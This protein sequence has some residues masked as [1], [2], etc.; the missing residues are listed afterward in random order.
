M[1]LRQERRPARPGVIDRASATDRAFL[2]MGDRRI[3]EQLGVALVL[4]PGDRPFD[5]ARAR[6]LVGDRSSAVPRLRQRLVAAPVGCGGPIWVDDAD[7]DLRR[8]VRSLACPAPGDERALLDV[9]ASL[10]ATPLPR[11]APLWSAVFVTG[12]ADGGVALVL[13][14]HHVLADGLG[15]LAVLACLADPGS[16][17]VDTGFPLPWP[18]RRALA[19]DALR[20]KARALHDLPTSWRLLRSSMGAGG[21]LHPERAEDCSLVAKTGQRCRLAVVRADA[22]VVHAAAHAH[23]ATTNDA[24]V[25]AVA[26][27]LHRLLE[28]RGEHVDRL[29]VTVPVSGRRTGA[30]AEMGNMV[31]P[32]LVSVPT[33]GDLD[34][35]LRAVA[36]QVR[37]QKAAATGPPPIALL[38]WAFRPLARLGGY[39]LYMDHQHRLHTLVSHVRGPAEPVAFDGAR[40]TSAIPVAVGGAGNMTVYVEVLSYAGALTLTVVADPQHVADRELELVADALRLELD[41]LRGARTPAHPKP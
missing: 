15:G 21:G 22:D 39:R 11:D 38:G 29:V 23:G 9:V 10:V 1:L 18:T 13:V 5:V 26:A 37:S 32:L 14:L 2:A 4:E 30:G 33:T 19:R 3:P 25:V 35:R 12:L 36:G 41:L 24:V 40:V 8:H 28:A 16:P 6:R 27:A 34:T 17:P 20:A 31:S 7:F